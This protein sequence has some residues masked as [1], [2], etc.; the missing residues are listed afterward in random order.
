VTK[1]RAELTAVIEKLIRAG[2]A[3]RAISLDALGDA[4]GTLAVSYPEIDAMIS[5]LEARGYQVVAP[6]NP[7]GEQHLREVL[8]AAR[9]LSGELGRRP[10]VGEICQRSGLD[11][12][13]VK[14]ALM[15]ARIMQR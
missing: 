14:H 12:E 11:P 2:R 13:Q 4:I 1:L 7:R 15:L 6:D 9:A 3:K 8:A 10:N 5:A